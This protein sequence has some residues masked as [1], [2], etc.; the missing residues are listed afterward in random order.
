MNISLTPELEAM[1]ADKVASGH[2]NSSSEVVR[3]GLRLLVEKDAL[4]QEQI[5]L[6]NEK[7]QVGLDQMEAGL[8]SPGE[9][10]FRRLREKM[11]KRK[12][13]AS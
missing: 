3:E 9:E 7:I 2:Y 13:D 5:K 11:A 12:R 8:G 4:R 6:L 10:V 1:I